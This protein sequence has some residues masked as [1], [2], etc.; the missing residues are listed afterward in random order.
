VAALQQIKALQSVGQ[1]SHQLQTV[2]QQ[3][4]QRRQSRQL[5]QISGS[6][7]L[8]SVDVTGFDDDDALDQASSAA[9]AC[10]EPEP[11]TSDEGPLSVTTRIEY[12]ALPHG[13]IQDVFGLVTVQAKSAPP[14]PD[15]GEPERQP[16]DILGVLDVSGSMQGDKLRQVQDATR[17]IIEQADPRDRLGLVSFNSTASRV[18]R[19]R[20]MTA[21]GKND[22]TV[23][24]LRLAAGGG[25]SIA[26]GLDMALAVMER[27]R[28]R[29]KVSVIL[30]LT[31]GQDG[32]TR[33]RLPDLVRRAAAANCAVYAFGFGTDH[34]SALLSELAEQAQTPFTFVEDTEKIREAFAGAVGGMSSIVAQHV[35][36]TLTS[37][38]ELKAVHTPFPLR[39]TAHEAVI[40]I[41]D[42]FALERR[43]ILVEVSVPAEGDAETQTVLLEASARYNDL[44]TSRLIQTASVFM[45]AQRVAEPQP[46][47]EPD[48]QVSAQRERVEVTRAL[49]EAS[50]ASD[51]GQFD[52]ALHTI[53]ECHGR[54][55]SSGRRT[56]V[57]DAMEQELEDAR[58][59]MRNR[60]AWEQGGRAELMDAAQMHKMQ[61]CTN[62]MQVSGRREKSSK[63]MYCSATQHE[64]IQKSKASSS[65]A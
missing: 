48:E 62:T 24:A 50:A 43:D 8:G 34:D 3:H 1:H 59:R 4:H 64:W 27:R 13:R 58:E 38:A 61:R 51:L 19:L 20:K 10:S 47:A 21:D 46:E 40:T 22:G 49:E 11:D 9:P 6:Y 56:S 18:L 5:R 57:S 14:P 65:R 32:S 2:Q 54:L 29:N 36:L 33:S 53:D 25:T 41:P 55:K 16:M 23:A 37:K 44:R 35:E 12:T 26:A 15:G 42:M 60:A 45:E 28:Q 39:Q 31:D 63:S 52:R 7:P 30:V 17:F